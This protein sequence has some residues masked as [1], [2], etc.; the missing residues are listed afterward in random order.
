[1]SFRGEF[2]VNSITRNEIKVLTGC[3]KYGDRTK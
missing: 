1:M 3:L 2:K